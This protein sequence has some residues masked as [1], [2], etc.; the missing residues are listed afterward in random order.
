M[1]RLLIGIVIATLFSLSLELEI[2]EN[3]IEVIGLVLLLLRKFPIVFKTDLVPKDPSY[4]LL[5]D[6][7]LTSLSLSRCT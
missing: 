6:S 2:I 7:L 4:T 5:T 3:K 1:I